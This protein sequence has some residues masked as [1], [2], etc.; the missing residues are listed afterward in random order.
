MNTRLSRRLQAIADRVPKG[1]LL[2]DIGSDHALLPS[3]LA[4]Q[5]RIKRGIA[6]ELNPGPFEAAT[7]Q[8]KESKL[9]HIV[10]VRRGDGLAVISP[11]EVNCITIAGMGGVLIASILE[12]GQDKLEGVQTMILQPNVG[13]EALRRWLLE[14]NWQLMEETILEEDDKIYEIIVAEKLDTATESNSKLFAERTVG[15][16]PS[17]SINKEW[18]LKMGPYLLAEPSSTFFKKWDLEI[19]KLE[20]ILKQLSQSELESSRAKEVEL[21]Q[22]INEIKGILACLPKDR[23]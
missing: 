13:E 23:P 3:Y 20:M 2:A 17:V 14:H 21:R 18:L 7:K 22:E 8:I 12:A 19:R 5:G 1:S 4:E 9:T 10:E 11:R 16:N 15:S 6:G